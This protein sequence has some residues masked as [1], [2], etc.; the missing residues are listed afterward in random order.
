MNW[1]NDSSQTAN[2]PRAPGPKGPRLNKVGFPEAKIYTVQDLGADSPVGKKIEILMGEGKPQKQ[3]VAT[4]LS[5]QRAGRLTAS[6]G[7]RRVKKK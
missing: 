2:W 4:A 3:A 5:M 1:P 6:G 7:Y